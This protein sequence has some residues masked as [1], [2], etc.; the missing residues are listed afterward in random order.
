MEPLALLSLSVMTVLAM[1]PGDPPK[2][3]HPN[4]TPAPYLAV[5]HRAHNAKATDPA[6]VRALVDAIFD[7]G[8]FANMPESVRER[9]ARAD[10][11]HRHGQ[12]R[13]ITEFDI[14]SA[15][16]SAAFLPGAPKFMKTST[17][18]IRGYRE[19]VRS[20]VPFIGSE[21][22]VP[23]PAD[24]E[25]S[26]GE[27]VL[28]LTA[29][30]TQKLFNPDYKMAPDEWV[31]NFKMKKENARRAQGAAHGKAEY[32][33]HITTADADTAALLHGLDSDL[34]DESS[35]ATM[36]IHLFLDQLGVPR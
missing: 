23:K 13:G 21:N 24:Q 35:I 5:L 19:I 11:A 17:D 28:V 15:V 27:A 18:Q 36:G 26:P 4:S 33:L 14:V 32:K 30:G 34:R 7:A 9:V 2:L 16:N 25:M 8:A 22:G 10:V 29:L 20:M 1:A 6:S 31:A 12:T 3:R